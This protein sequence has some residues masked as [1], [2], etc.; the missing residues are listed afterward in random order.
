[1]LEE[2]AMKHRIDSAL[3]AAFLATG[4]AIASAFMAIAPS[5]MSRS[6]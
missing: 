6:A 3:L 5:T 4:S 2:S 1:M